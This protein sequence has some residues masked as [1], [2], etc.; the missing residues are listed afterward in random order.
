M[1][2]RLA[3]KSEAKCKRY[4]FPLALG[5]HPTITN[6]MFDSYLQILSHMRNPSGLA[7][8][9]GWDLPGSND[10][11]RRVSRRRQPRQ[12]TLWATPWNTGSKS[13]SSRLGLDRWV[14]IH[15]ISRQVYIE[16]HP[17]KDNL[18]DAGQ[19]HNPQAPQG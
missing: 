3:P 8:P 4:S 14:A 5:K 10:G 6:R 18:S 16:R 17:L 12:R 2:A 7:D 1:S 9:F 11:K 19:H 13:I 15:E